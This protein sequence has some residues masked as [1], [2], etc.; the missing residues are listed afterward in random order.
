MYLAVC[1][2]SIPPGLGCQSYLLSYAGVLGS[3]Q[4]SSLA[5]GEDDNDG[6]GGDQA[7]DGTGGDEA[8]AAGKGEDLGV[9]G[10]G[11]AGGEGGEEGMGEGA[12]EGGMG[13]GGAGVGPTASGTL[14]A[15]ALGAR[16]SDRDI[17]DG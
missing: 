13:R 15:G 12:E 8:L 3:V 1:S 16:V 7:D 9:E 14:R 4:V 17:L 6:G 5:S 10:E 11:E 2:C